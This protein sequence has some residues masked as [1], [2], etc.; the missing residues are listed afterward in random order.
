MTTKIAAARHNAQA[1]AAARPKKV[2]LKKNREIGA[3]NH[4][5]GFRK[6]DDVGRQGSFMNEFLPLVRVTLGP[7]LNHL[8]GKG[9]KSYFIVQRRIE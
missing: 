7:V 1:F 4:G 2:R 6:L 9:R 5:N 3:A 8:Y